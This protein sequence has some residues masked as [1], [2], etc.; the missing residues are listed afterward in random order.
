MPENRKETIKNLPADRGRIQLNKRYWVSKKKEICIHMKLTG[1]VVGPTQDRIADLPQ[2]RYAQAT[3]Q[4]VAV[5]N[6]PVNSLWVGAEAFVLQI[7]TIFLFLMYSHILLS[8]LP[9]YPSTVPELRRTCLERSHANWFAR[10]VQKHTCPS[11]A[12]RLV[13]V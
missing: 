3:G 11:W 13:N 7:K 6:A 9:F 8:S 12:C 4:R 5:C 2:A 1:E 10:S